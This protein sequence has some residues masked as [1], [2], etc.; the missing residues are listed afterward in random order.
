MRRR[1]VA[2]IAPFASELEAGGIEYRPIVFSCYGRPHPDA[3][4][5]VQS[6]ARRLARRRGTEAHIEERRLAARIGLQI[7]RRAARML[8]HCLPETAELEAELE[9][10]A[11]PIEPAVQWRVGH[12]ASV[13]PEAVPPAATGG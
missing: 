5:L 12:P 6:L 7:W 4:R 10:D 11:A 9:R 2:R 1:K 8:R 13:E 3:Q